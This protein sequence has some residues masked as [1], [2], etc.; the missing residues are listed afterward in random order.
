MLPVTPPESL[1]S[2]LWPSQLEDLDPIVTAAS[3]GS[4]DAIK[5]DAGEPQPHTLSDA[6]RFGLWIASSP[7][8]NPGRRAAALPLYTH[9]PTLSRTPSLQPQAT[10]RYFATVSWRAS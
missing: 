9:P 5:L 3:T 4:D 6:P 8:L 10:W 2:P 1:V 7:N